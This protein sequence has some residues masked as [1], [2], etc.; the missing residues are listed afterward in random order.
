[1][2]DKQLWNEMTESQKEFVKLGIQIER[3]RI[4]KLLKKLK[5]TQEIIEEIQK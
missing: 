3:D 1:M 5:A 4:A 2:I